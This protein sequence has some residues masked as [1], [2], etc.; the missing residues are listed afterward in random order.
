MIRSLPLTLGRI[1]AFA[2]LLIA[3]SQRTHGQ[4]A[5]A[6]LAQEARFDITAEGEISG[7]TAVGGGASI[8]RPGWLKD[9][10]QAKAYTVTFPVAPFLSEETAIRFVPKST[11]EIQVSLSGRWEEIAPG[12]RSRQ[13]VEW[14]S[15]KLDGA[16]WKVGAAPSEKS[17]RTWHD[18]PV[19]LQVMATANQPVTIRTTA[20]PVIPEGQRVMRRITRKD[21]PAHQALAR[22]R[23]GANAGNYLEVP[24][25]QNWSVPHS[26]EDIAQMKKEGFDHV[27]IPAGFHHYTGPA[28]E[29]T[30]APAFFKKVDALLEAAK[31]QKLGAVLNIHHFDPLNDDPAGEKPRFLAIWRQIAERYADSP[32]SV[33]FELLNE[34]HTKATTEV[35]NG[36][37][38]EAIA[39]IRKTNPKRTIFV[40]PSRWNQATEL[41]LMLLPDDDENLIVTLHCYDPF[42]FTH[43]GAS[44]ISRSD[45]V[46][47]VIFPG[48]PSE[49]LNV[50]EGTKQDLRDWV[51]RYNTLPTAQNPSSAKAFEAALQ[52]AEK[53]S[54]YYGRPIHWGEFGAYTK[55]DDASRAR[56]YEAFRRAAEAAGHGWAIW[57]WRAGFRYW[58]GSRNAPAPGLRD[59]LFAK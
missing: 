35:M 58:D 34:P 14:T 38:A 59:A 42:F 56:Y 18:K 50:P 44:W 5:P 8:S 15:V 45:G 10:A 39:I 40:G 54:E 30:I 52:L 25:S 20:I 28:P 11:G 1:T 12:K 23:R 26:A 16:E 46:T 19:Q 21:S 43:Q 24:P 51:E 13:E 7:G 32:D 37:Y 2:A 31:A 47:G 17:I 48:P 55:S 3:A 49:P 36:I 22:F 29:Y 41:P 57:D 6:K 33:G 53:W 27:R 4:E 9:E